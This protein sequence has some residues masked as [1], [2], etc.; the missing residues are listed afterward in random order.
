MTKTKLFLFFISLFALT[1]TARAD[2]GTGYILGGAV[3]GALAGY[4]L[5][6]QEDKDEQK[7]V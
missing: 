4:I 2:G 1:N 6:D 5:S 7:E 3:F